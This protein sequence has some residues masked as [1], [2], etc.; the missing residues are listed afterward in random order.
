[1][2]KRFGATRLGIWTIKH[3]VAPLDRRLYTSTD[4]RFVTTGKA[5]APIL[6][7]TTTGRK[8]GS[9]YT[10]PVFYLTDANR[11]IICNANPGFER[12]N[13]WVLNL[14]ANPH[15]TVQLGAR[16]HSCI[17]RIAAIG[18]VEQ[19]WPRFTHLWPAYQE[20]YERS[21]ERTL[22]ILEHLQLLE[23]NERS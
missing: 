22:F 23:E 20:Y 3:L 18:E 14:R 2:L 12:V 21:G 17:A 1:M 5:V 10:N 6:L 13:P 8:S 19:Y 11:L 4:G 7:L 15:A 9:L 16:K